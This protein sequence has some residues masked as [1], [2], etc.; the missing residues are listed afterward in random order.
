MSNR[1]VPGAPLA[2][3]HRV[4]DRRGVHAGQRLQTFEHRQVELPLRVDVGIPREVAEN[5]RRQHAVRSIPGLDTLQAVEAG[6]QQAGADQQH[7]RDRHLRHD[8]RALDSLAAAGVAG[9]AA[10]LL[11]RVDEI[12]PAAERR[13]RAEQHSGQDRNAERE[14]QHDRIQRDLARARRKPADE[15]GQHVDGQPRDADA[16]GAADHGEQRALGQQLPHQAAAAG[17][18]RGAHRQLAIAAQHPRQR[19]VGDIR[20]RDQQHQSGDAEQDQQQLPR[21]GGEGFAHGNGRGAEAGRLRP[22]DRLEGAVLR[23]VVA[24]RADGARRLLRARAFLQTGRTR[25]TRRTRAGSAPSA[26][27]RRRGTGTPA[28]ACRRRSPADSAARSAARRS[29]GAADR[30]SRTPG[31]RCSDRR[32]TWCASRCGSGSAPPRRRA[33]RLTPRT[34]GR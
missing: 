31:R 9:L 26:V 8:Q 13:Q 34:C 12:D 11:Q 28:P 21:P 7:H 18:E 15:R 10:A 16:D 23:E 17:A 22:V 20:A 29:R 32:R 1:V 3:R 14:D 30:S 4:G 5:L 27:R 6:Q 33:Y 19:E 25:S 24:D 2:K